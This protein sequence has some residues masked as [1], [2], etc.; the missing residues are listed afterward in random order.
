M[1][2][3]SKMNHWSQASKFNF[4]SNPAANQDFVGARKTVADFVDSGVDDYFRLVVFEIDVYDI[5]QQLTQLTLW[6][7]L[8]R[9]RE[10]KRKSFRPTNR[11]IGQGERFL[12]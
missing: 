10:E 1:T 9:E 11:P 8:K 12:F 5:Y 3:L 4:R 2:K 6:T 7:I